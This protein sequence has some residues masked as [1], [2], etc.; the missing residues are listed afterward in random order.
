MPGRPIPSIHPHGFI[1]NGSPGSSDDDAR[2]YYEGRRLPSQGFSPF[3]ADEEE[4]ERL[5]IVHK[6]THAVLGSHYF[7]PVD[8]LLHKP[9]SGGRRRR[10]L[11]VGTGTG[12]WVREMA[13][14]FPS[15]DFVGVDIIRVPAPT[16]LQGGSRSL[17]TTPA[18]S[19]LLRSA[20]DSD[21][22]LPELPNVTFERAD[23]IQGLRH[24]DAEFD[25]VH[26]RNVLS[27]AIPAYVTAIRDFTRV[28]RPT[29]LLLLAETTVPFSL[30]D[31]GAHQAES[32]LAEF[33]E[34]IQNALRSIGLDPEIRLTLESFIRKGPFADSGVREIV[35]P[36]GDWSQDSRLRKVGRLG[37]EALEMTLRSLTPLLRQTGYDDGRL[38]MLMSR[39]HTELDAERP[40]SGTGTAL[41]STYLWA[42]K[43]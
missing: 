11:D 33:T 18:P 7:G 9:T 13:G 36:L 38:S 4:N 17:L 40:G 42:R 35:I 30:S 6:V 21:D 22:E 32:A 25:V 5:R 19:I 3:P 1:S 24:T 16:E 20:Y 8:R 27:V 41:V 12:D 34:A 2:F 28:L 37:R 43:K 26:C 29:G 14:I 10:V 23:I 39:I 15:T 31:G